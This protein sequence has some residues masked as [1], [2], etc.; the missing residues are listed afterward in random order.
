[1]PSWRSAAIHDDRRVMIIGQSEAK[2]EKTPIRCRPD[3]L[4]SIA[5]QPL[6]RGGKFCLL[7]P[8]HRPR[9]LTVE[10]ETVILDLALSICP[11]R[12]EDQDS[13]LSSLRQGFES[14]WGHY[15]CRLIIHPCTLSFRAPKAIWLYT[16]GEMDDLEK[17]SER[18]DERPDYLLWRVFCFVWIVVRQLACSRYH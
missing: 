17:Q 15:L 16:V 10:G 7:P 18:F 2:S 8:A 5:L 9:N 3:P 4:W 13:G 6:A 1:M 11:H 14:P 12:L